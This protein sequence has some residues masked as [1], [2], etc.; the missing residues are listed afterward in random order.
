MAAAR[1]AAA[2]TALALFTGCAADPSADPPDDQPAA[3]EQPQLS[4]VSVYGRHAAVRGRV[5]VR[6]ANQ[7]GT[8]VE[9]AS[10]RIEHPLFELVPVLERTSTLPAD[11]RARIVPVP[12]GAPRCDTD[13]ADGAQVV[14]GLQTADGVRDVAVPLADGE[15]GLVR[16]HR[17]ACSADAVQAAVEFALGG[18]VLDGDVARATLTV[19]RRAAGE[20]V[21]SGVVGTVLFGVE[22]SPGTVALVLAPEQDVAELPLVVRPARCEAH[23][24][25]EA[26]D[27]FAFPVVAS[28]DGAE[29]A[30]LRLE[31]G[32]QGR[33]VLQELLTTSCHLLD[34]PGPLG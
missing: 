30:R 9:I 31:A 27:V 11:G 22:P 13:D 21:V 20:V 17:L 18:W 14:V 16:A 3:T 33:A 6:I 1:T 15:P 12:F 28:L 7:G 23:A 25:T 4:A 29:P 2:L 5:D 26:K 10:Y 34:P 32:R 8:P 19:R 24:L